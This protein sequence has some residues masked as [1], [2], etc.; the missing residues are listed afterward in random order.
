MANLSLEA[1]SRTPFMSLSRSLVFWIGLHLL[2]L[3]G[4]AWPAITARRLMKQADDHL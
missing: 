2:W 4:T 3:I 1:Q